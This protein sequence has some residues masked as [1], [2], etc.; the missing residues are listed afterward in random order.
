MTYEEA[1]F[2][3]LLR[4]AGAVCGSDAEAWERFVGGLAEPVRR[5]IAEEFFWQAHGGQEEP[6][7]SAAGNWR[8]WL[9]MAGRGF[10]KTRA[11]AEWVSAR[12]RAMP[13][14]E[15]AL[16][17]ASRDEV[18]RVMVEGP[19]GLIAVARSDEALEWVP[20]RGVLR[21]T[22][23]ARAFV[24]SAAAPDQL[25]GP[26]HHFAWC[27]EIAKWRRGEEAWD[28]LMMGLRMGARPRAMVTTTP[29]PV[30]IVRRLRV[31]PDCIETNG[32]T[33]D[34]VHMAAAFRDWAEA[35]YGGTRLGRQELDGVLFEEPEGAL[36][37]RETIE[38]A[39][40]ERPEALVRVVVGVD[41]PASAAGD[42]CG[43]VVCGLGAD[44]VSYVLADRSV[45][46]LRP[47]GWAQAVVRAAA[48]WEADRVVAEKNQ[49]G[50]MVESVLRGVEAG[51]PVTTVS[52]SRGKA[53]RAEPIAARFEQGKA[54]LAGRF[55][56]LEDELAGLLAA[57][58]Y[59]GPGRS[60]DRAD[61]MVWALTELARPQ[62]EPRLRCF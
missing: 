9:L 4:R 38:A 52:A 37:T 19:S 27:D 11:G 21:F 13:G 44:G 32:R 56:E 3:D 14:A 46:G 29:K 25:R 5:R 30:A 45:S 2:G 22:S 18:R 41:P 62:A 6:A 49:G 15:I 7:A 33:A 10:G 35:T 26:Q 24:Y 28:N 47:E 8:V 1:D 31:L 17:G 58:G 60:P 43:I 23:G 54:K 34:N 16:V 39:R 61:A 59:E 48:T 42:A 40:A 36:W 20:T 50:D 12:A 57:G 51:L 53:A 55:P